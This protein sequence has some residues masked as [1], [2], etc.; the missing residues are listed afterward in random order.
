MLA[1]FGDHRPSIP[2]IV[3]PGGDRD[4]PFVLLRFGAGSDAEA[5]GSGAAPE[6]LTP[7][8]LHRALLREATSLLL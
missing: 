4:T 7:A 2:G 5:P 3:E 6:R 1:F 8:G